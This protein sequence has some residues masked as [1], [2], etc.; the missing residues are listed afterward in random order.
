MK[1]IM[2]SLLSMSVV[3]FAEAAKE[4]VL[5]AEK[6]NL[7]PAAKVK[8]S[9]SKKA[10]IKAKEIAA[11]MQPVVSVSDE[12]C[13]A[14]QTVKPGLNGFAAS[15][16]TGILSVKSNVDNPDTGFSVSNNNRYKRVGL[17]LTYYMTKENN[18][19]FGW[20]LDLLSEF[21]QKTID[22]KGTV[23]LLPVDPTTGQP[24]NFPIDKAV[25]MKYT[26]KR[27]FTANLHFKL[28]YAYGNFIPYVTLGMRQ[29]YV[30]HERLV[31]DRYKKMV[32]GVDKDVNFGFAPGAGFMYK[33]G[34][35]GVGAD[36]SY[37]KESTFGLEGYAD[38]DDQVK[39]KGGHSV[40][41]RLSY[42][43]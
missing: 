26:Q 28:G 29:S 20:G 9:K 11:P 37:H 10:K 43:F 13:K 27:P 30:R 38:K 15:I 32:K 31:E 40:M 12:S 24:V 4:N 1:K 25:D 23:K 22:A 5:I 7:V 2:T 36:Y 19:V 42:F 34:K 39:S 16:V 6:E 8:V 33:I 3:L 17:G 35:F 41:L 14:L 21:G 18:V